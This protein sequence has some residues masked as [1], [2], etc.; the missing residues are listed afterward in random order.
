MTDSNESMRTRRPLKRSY[1]KEEFLA[2]CGHDL[3]AIILNFFHESCSA[4]TRITAKNI[5]AE[6]LL[7]VSE[8]SILNYVAKLVLLGFVERR[9]NPYESD[10]VY[11]YKTNYEAIK[12]A[13]KEKGY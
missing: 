10:R 5:K 3:T 8:K 6:T 11:I 13:L 12:K 7:N 1:L 2:I 9:K 4:W